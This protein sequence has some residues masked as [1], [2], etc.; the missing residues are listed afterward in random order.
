M[1][2]EGGADTGPVVLVEALASGRPVVSTAVGMAPRVVVDGVNGHL[3]PEANP[4]ALAD[5]LARVRSADG[6]MDDARDADGVPA[7][8]RP[9]LQQ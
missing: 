6:S 3:V 8:L 4:R 7:R 2:G 9:G 5:A 1:Q